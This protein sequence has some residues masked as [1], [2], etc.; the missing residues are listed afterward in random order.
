MTPRYITIDF[1]GRV[2]EVTNLYDRF[3]NDTTDP[4]L[5]ATCVIRLS[6]NEWVPGDTDDVPIYTVH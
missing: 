3:G 6:A 5:A 2:H 1:C 4:R